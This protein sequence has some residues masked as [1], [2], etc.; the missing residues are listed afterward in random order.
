MEMGAPVA[1]SLIVTVCA[2][3]VAPVTP[4]TTLPNAIVRGETVS[5]VAKADAADDA[6]E[7]TIA[8][9]ANARTVSAGKPSFRLRT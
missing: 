8:A 7:P 5:P 4:K 6:I 1:G 3:L 2:A 9:N